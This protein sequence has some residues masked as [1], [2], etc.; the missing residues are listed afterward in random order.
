M[1]V[2]THRLIHTIF[3]KGSDG[4]SGGKAHLVFCKEKIR[5]KT[6]FWAQM[7]W[8]IA[9][10]GSAGGEIMRIICI[11]LLDFHSYMNPEGKPLTCNIWQCYYCQFDPLNL[12]C[13][14][15][16]AHRL[17]YSTGTHRGPAAAPVSITTKYKGDKRLRTQS[18][19]MEKDT[20]EVNLSAHTQ[21]NTSFSIHVDKKKNTSIQG[22]IS[23]TRPCCFPTTSLLK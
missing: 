4:F 19:L 5:F 15:C 6:I 3:W 10:R 16:G 18:D 7:G 2:Q 13:L 22:V 14:G 9:L 8:K 12:A 20:W 1:W 17:R 11:K 21:R 23:H